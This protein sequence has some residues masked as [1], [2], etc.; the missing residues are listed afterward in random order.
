MRRFLLVLL[1]FGSA[2]AFADD[3]RLLFMSGSALEKFQNIYVFLL[4]K[5]ILTPYEL[6][7]Y[8][9]SDGFRPDALP[10]LNLRDDNEKVV[11]LERAREKLDGLKD[12]GVFSHFEPKSFRD[13][14]LRLVKD[15]RGDR[16]LTQNW[17]VI[18]FAGR[19]WIKDDGKTKTWYEAMAHCKSLGE[20]VRLPTVKELA[21]VQAAGI[22]EKREVFNLGWYYWSS[23]DAASSSTT[24]ILKSAQIV[25][26]H[27]GF[28]YNHP[29]FERSRVLCIRS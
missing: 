27:S 15:I 7:T 24:A 2:L 22:Y 6:E 21:E 12:K 16:A 23:D 8:A 4:N 9:N 25:Q 3:C 1:L 18:G 19:F 5:N 14:L 29:K 17:T 26:L 20:G 10:E 13:V 28:V 11:E